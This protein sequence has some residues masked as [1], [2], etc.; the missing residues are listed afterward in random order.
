[1]AQLIFHIKH[2]DT[3]PKIRFVLRDDTE[4]PVD[5]TGW[6][7]RFHMG[8]KGWAAVLVDAPAVIVDA[9]AGIGEYAWATGDT[10]RIGDFPWEVEGTDPSGGVWSFP[11]D[12]YGTVRIVREIQ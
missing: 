8:A 3:R 7:L 2:G 11:N 4:E 9:P 1:V 12:G 6:T 10:N 5:L